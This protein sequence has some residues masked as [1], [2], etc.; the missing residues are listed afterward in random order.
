MNFL[1]N[2]PLRLTEEEA[3]ALDG[4][5]AREIFGDVADLYNADAT[6]GSFSELPLE[7][8]TAIGDLAYQ[9]GPNLEQRLPN[10]WATWRR[11]AGTKR[12]RP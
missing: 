1:A 4:A 6:E 11:G 8:R 5:V 2:R 3:Y 10:F 12:R 7:A 9:Y